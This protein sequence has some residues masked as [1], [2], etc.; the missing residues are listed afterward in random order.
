MSN[1]TAGPEDSL[2]PLRRAPR[3]RPFVV[4]QLGQSLDGRIA[5]PTGASKWI[6][7]A[8][9]LDHLHRLR[10]EVDAVLV[11]CGTVIADDP[12]L[13]VRRVTGRDP[14]RVVIDRN[15]RTPDSARVFHDNGPRRIVIRSRPGPVPAGV[16]TLIVSERDSE[17]DPAEIIAALAGEG[18][19]RI[20]I[21]GGAAT[22]SKFIDANAVD[23]LHLLVSPVI[24][25]SGVS[26]LALA[27][28]DRL[29]E[30]RRPKTSLHILDDGDVL[31]DCNLR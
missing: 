26:G 14:A 17:F 15:G 9:A 22:V 12:R 21:E 13:N 7:G 29:D 20:L 23:R 1:E 24:L 10:A 25:G 5:T 11:G 30:A 31:F 4:A 6:S 3:H 28:I 19:N 16:E 2:T 8:G 27:P 18:L